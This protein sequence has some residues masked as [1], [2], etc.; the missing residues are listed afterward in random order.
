[1]ESITTLFT[2][3]T[4]T[5]T[6]VAFAVCVFFVAVGGIIYATAAGSP[7]Q[8]ETGKA[9]IVNA[10]LGLAIVLG[11]RTIVGLISTALGGSAG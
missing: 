6:T 7:R 3:L 5:I 9:A 2:N 10:L 1:M 4:T 8:A 11:A